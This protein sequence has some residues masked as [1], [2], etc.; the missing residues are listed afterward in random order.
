MSNLRRLS[1]GEKKLVREWNWI[2]TNESGRL[3]DLRLDGAVIS[4][5]HC[6]LKAH[7]V[8][9]CYTKRNNNILNSIQW[10]WWV[11]PASTHTI[12]TRF[13][14]PVIRAHNWAHSKMLIQ[15]KKRPV[16]SV[17]ETAWAI[18]FYWFTY[19]VLIINV[20]FSV[21]FLVCCSKL[22]TRT[23]LPANL[24]NCDRLNAVIAGGG[25]IRRFDYSPV[26]QCYQVNSIQYWWYES[27]LIN[28]IHTT[29]SSSKWLRLA[30]ICPM[31]AHRAFSH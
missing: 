11:P 21:S 19:R 7:L 14:I 1:I 30:R 16:N 10:I 3:Q 18:K 13:C 24:P 6:R 15:K 2:T 28:A 25:S 22:I 26:P 4:Q 5:C 17:P 27:Y 9:H 23:D 31:L 12:W 8:W 29:N 20:K